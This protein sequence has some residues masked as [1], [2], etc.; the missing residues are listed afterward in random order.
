[1]SDRIVLRGLRAHGFHGVFDFERRDGQEFVVDVALE[2]DTSEAA[3]S[4]DLSDTVD[5]GAL[6]DRLVAVLGGEPSNLLEAVAQKLADVCLVDERVEAATV[7][8]H[9]P[10]APIPHTFADVSV[11]IRRVRPDDVEATG[12]APFGLSEVQE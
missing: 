8:L 7:T 2:L 3:A 9:K 12:L 10:Q 6:A 4:D 1:L 11:T 5:Y